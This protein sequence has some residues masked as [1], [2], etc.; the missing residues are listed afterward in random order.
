MGVRFGA[1][2]NIDVKGAVWRWIR[3]FH[4]A[5]YKEH[6]D[7]RALHAI[8]V[9]FADGEIVDGNVRLSAI[10]EQRPY[11]VEV[12]KMNRDAQRLDRINSNAGAV[13]YE[14]VWGQMDDH[15]P[16]LCVFALD[17]YDWRDLGEER[18]GHRGCVGC[19]QTNHVPSGATVETRTP[20]AVP[21]AD[22]LDPF[23]S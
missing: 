17:I 1:V 5:L 20:N 19:Y 10:R 9:P 14:C 18:L 11:F 7:D 16:W 8:E 3:G 22:Q 12:I 15:A 4:A 23:G 6:L 21:N 2:T 13:T